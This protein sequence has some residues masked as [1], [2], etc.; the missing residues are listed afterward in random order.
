MKPGTTKPALTWILALG[1]GL[2]AGVSMSLFEQGMAK[3]LV[4]AILIA[5]FAFAST[6]F[7]R[8]RKRVAVVAWLAGS[9][10]AAVAAVVGRYLELGAAAEVMLGENASAA[11]L[12]AVTEAAMSDAKLPLMA[13]VFTVVAFLVALV[14]L[15]VGAVA[16]P[17][18]PAR[19]LTATA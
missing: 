12:A 8:T 9:A 19:Q 14:P 11:E 15:F 4:P 6:F 3:A 18:A 13:V 10:A 2:A 7:S 17:K 1:G 5:A 16:R